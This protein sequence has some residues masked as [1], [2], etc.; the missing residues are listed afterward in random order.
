M[1]RLQAVQAQQRE[2]LFN[3]NQKYLYEMTNYYPD[4][5]DENGNLHYGYFDRYFTDPRRQA[6]FLFDDDTLVGFAMLNPYSCIGGQP[7]HTMAEFTIFPMYRRKHFARDGASDPVQLSRPLGDQ[8]QRKKPSRQ[9]AVD[10]PCGAVPSNRSSPERRGD[11]T[12][13]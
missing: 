10:V 7:D 3:L 4:P 5:L 2:T 8:V 9:K 11:G 6:F 12:G 13:V 1:I